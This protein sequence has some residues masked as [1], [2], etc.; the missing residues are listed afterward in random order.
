[1][2]PNELNCLNREERRD[3]EAYGKSISGKHAAGTSQLLAGRRA[4]VDIK[5]AMKLW[6]RN[7]VGCF[8][9]VHLPWLRIGM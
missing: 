1:M 6:S 8:L 5:P 4:P 7:L 3:G 9:P 2:A